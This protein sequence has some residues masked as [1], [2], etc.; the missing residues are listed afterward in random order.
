MFSDQYSVTASSPWDGEAPAE[1]KHSSRTV[2]VPV[3]VP[4]ALAVLR[5]P[6]GLNH[7]LT[8]SLPDLCCIVRAWQ[9]TVVADRLAR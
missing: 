7:P 4:V 5:L 8:A 9:V 2:P 6:S 3:P 1:P